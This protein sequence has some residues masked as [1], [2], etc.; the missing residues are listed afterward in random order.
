MKYFVECGGP[1][2]EGRLCLT[3]TCLVRSR[4]RVCRSESAACR[5]ESRWHLTLAFT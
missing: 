1:W 5:C 2:R 4:L 3:R